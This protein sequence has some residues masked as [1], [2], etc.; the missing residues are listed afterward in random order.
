MGKPQE[1][2]PPIDGGAHDNY[3]TRSRR[4]WT[5]CPPF[6]THANKTHA[7][8]P[9]IPAQTSLPG[10]AKY[11]TCLLALRHATVM[12]DGDVVGLRRWNASYY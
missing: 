3:T 4:F 1:D 7:G 2:S 11:S 6:Q 5:G 12:D 10:R 8:G 9:R